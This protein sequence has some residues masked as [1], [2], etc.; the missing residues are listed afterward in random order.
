MLACAR[1]CAQ[2]RGATDAALFSDEGIY[3]RRA[4]LRR[5][6]LGE[7]GP[8]GAPPGAGFLLVSPN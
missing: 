8:P 7:L 4:S 6:S 2:F 5:L 1:L 3:A